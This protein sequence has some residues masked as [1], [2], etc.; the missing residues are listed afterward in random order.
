ALVGALAAWLGA[1]HATVQ[2]RRG[3]RLMTAGFFLY[4]IGQLVWDLQIWID[5]K[6]FPLPSDL[7]YAWLGPGLCIGLLDQALRHARPGQRIT[8]LL[9]CALMAVASLTL[10]LALYLP[11]SGDITPL[12]LLT[13]IA[14]PATLFTALGIGL[15]MIPSLHLKL[16]LGYLSF[17]A[18]LL[19]ISLCWIFW[20][21]LA[22]RGGVE[23]NSLLNSM[24]SVSIAGCGIAM[25]FWRLERSTQ[26]DWVRFCEGL[27]RLMPLLAVI[28]ACSGVAISIYG[29]SLHGAVSREVSYIILSGATAAIVLA[30]LRQRK[31]L[32]DFQALQ[33]VT[34]RAERSE[35]L[36]NIILE[37]LPDM[38]WMKDADGVYLM[39]NPGVE[40]LYNIQKKDLLGKTDFDFNPPELAHFFR[41]KDLEAILSGGP[42]K[43]EEWLTSASDGHYFLVET[44]KTPIFQADGTVLGVMGIARDITARHEMETALKESEARLRLIGDNLPDGYVY[45]YVRDRDNKPYFLYLSAGVERVNGV[46]AQDAMQNPQLLLNQIDRHQ[47][48]DFL[49]AEK[50]SAENLADFAME[51]RMTNPDGKVHWIHLRSHPYRRANGSI[52]WDGI[53]IDFT[54]QRQDEER[55]RLA[56][57][58]FSDAHEGIIIATADLRIIDV[59]PYFTSITGYSREEAIGNPASFLYSPDYPPEFYEGVITSANEQGFWQGD[60]WQYRKNGEHYAVSVALSVLRDEQGAVVNYICLISD[61]THVKYQQETLELM[62]HYDALTRLPNRVLFADRFKQ[63]IAH[64]RRDNSLLAVC[65]LDLDGFKQVNDQHGHETGDQLLIEAARRIQSCLREEDTISRLGG[66]EFALLLGNVKSVE[67]LKSV[68]TRIHQL[69]SQPYKIG[70]KQLHVAVSSGATL[71]PLDDANPDTLIR[72]ADQAMYRAKQEGRNRFYLFDPSRD[73]ETRLHRDVQDAV[74]RGLQ[75]HEFCLY[76]QPKVNMRTGAVAGLEALLRWHHPQRGLLLPMDFLPLVADTAQEQALGE[77]A[78][79]EALQQME[80]WRSAGLDIKVSI[81]IS[82]RHLLQRNF[83]SQLNQI[84]RQHDP[85]LAQQ[86]ELE[87]S[88]AGVPEDVQSAGKLIDEC[89]HNMGVAFTL[90]DFGTGTSSLSHLRHLPVHTIKIDHGFVRNMIA[91]ADD[92]AVVEGLMGLANAFR[93]EAV[94]KGVETPA[95]CVAL[96]KLGCEL[97][98]G[99]GIARPMPADQIPAWVQSS[100]GGARWLA[101]AAGLH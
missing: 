24:F 2:N 60:L 62:A 25:L 37:T 95:H 79:H 83:S 20:N 7:F 26:P 33:T 64:S 16:S 87:V 43:N 21:L 4:A 45:Q 19:V 69:V 47:I 6:G 34:H 98:Q 92:R 32:Q 57:R 61:I 65:Y 91:N 17:L 59:N 28:A 94:A 10:V 3:M 46:S 84:L 80:T 29:D 100:N 53:A 86:L 41:Q 99:Y 11:L 89:S 23:T 93:R 31:L 67:Q 36:N 8:L 70:D 72:H 75:A 51:V 52:V 22:L 56:A 96:L 76:Y 50:E 14:Y 15:V 85:A 74:E 68:M 82:S 48:K 88:E 39:S 97:G 78:M 42:R 30:F 1:R 58:V 18:G 55:L 12:A 54:Q 38:V 27:L 101:M 44:I 73:L 35:Q 5:Y 9:D 63:A 13:L 77:W 66:D 71:Y 90:D 81:N 40:K 49:L